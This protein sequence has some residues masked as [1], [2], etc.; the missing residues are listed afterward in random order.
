MSG[1]IFRPKRLN[2]SRVG[3][4]LQEGLKFPLCIIIAGVGYGKSTSVK[5]YLESSTWKRIWLPMRK[6]KDEV[7]IWKRL[8]EQFV[9][10][11]FGNEIMAEELPRDD[12]SRRRLIDLIKKKIKVPFVLIL[13]DF[14]KIYNSNFNAMIEDV[15]NA[16]IPNFHIL[17][18]TRRYPDIP[19]DE[20]FM[21]DKCFLI[22]QPIMSFTRKDI[23]DFFALNEIFLS[24]EENEMINEHTEG[25]T[26]AI[27]LMLLSFLQTGTVENI[28]RIIH[29]TKTTVFNRLDQEEKDILAKLSLLDNFSA[30]QGAYIAEK[31]NEDFQRI[32]RNSSNSINFIHYD[33][34]SELYRMHN[35]LRSVAY[36]ELLEEN[37]DISELWTRTGNW[38]KKTEDTVGAIHC[39]V[40]A[41]KP[42][43]A[44]QMLEEINIF[45]E[46]MKAPEVYQEFFDSISIEVKAKYLKP[47]LSY[48]YNMALLDNYAKA[49]KELSAL[50]QFCRKQFK[51]AP[52]RKSKRNYSEVMTMSANFYF[53]DIDKMESELDKVYNL[54][55]GEEYH[56]E[57][58]DNSYTALYNVPE[59]LYIYYKK[60]G[61]LQENK[62]KIKSLSR[63]YLNLIKFL[64]AG[65]D[66]M[67]DGEYKYVTGDI[68]EAMKYSSI[69]FEK[70][71]YQKDIRAIIAVG[72]LRLRCC[73]YLGE[74]D[75]FTE[76]YKE[77]QSFTESIN[78]NIINFNYNLIK[79]YIELC[80]GRGSTEEEWIEKEKITLNNVHK[81]A[82][83]GA[84]SYGK[85]LCRDKKYVQLESL[86]EN[87]LQTEG[88]DNFYGMQIRGKVFLSIA[89]KHLFG[90]EL[91]KKELA[92]TI[93][94]ARPDGIISIFMEMSDELMDIL[95]ELDSN[96]AYIKKIIM[97][98]KRYREGLRVVQS[99]N[100]RQGK[101]ML[102]TAR[103]Y[104]M[105]NLVKRGY[106]N[107]EISNE[108]H[109]AV[110]TVEKILSGIY[111]KLKVPNRQGALRVLQDVL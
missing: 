83:C 16:E 85:I 26:S 102:L 65:W 10:N 22:E 100:G 78:L 59:V 109:V 51:A 12:Q 97:H 48:L 111:R 68:D 7:W 73:I 46:Y 66:W 67:V 106:T 57:I 34:K 71:L 105:M 5:D 3:R 88:A 99:S 77:M 13:D 35:L 94:L 27:Y 60:A 15:V 20:W 18:I 41:G 40:R 90:M 110:V 80:I 33:I 58:L 103:E 43:V 69:A 76:T 38:M 84:L 30:E 11:G 82:Q 87:L 54:W 25:W 62:E 44:L 24:D 6:E 56:S 79:E 64:D 1:R 36:D 52:C 17:I 2:R 74:R 42:E 70:A 29:M 31:G 53:N 55:D 96:D 14:H 95:K 9:E 75:K 28:N 39:Y 37:Y 4:Y 89:I 107:A 91:A 108:L 104:E 32:L 98:C 45:N 19:Y 61:S 81:F 47:Y 8:C 63:K 101:A 21:K 86:A 72:G 23:N 50:Y 93:E 92:E 49:D